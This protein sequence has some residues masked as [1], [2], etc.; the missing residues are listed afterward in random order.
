[1]DRRRLG[2]A[3]LGLFGLWALVLVE[4]CGGGLRSAHPAREMAT[5][6]SSSWDAPPAGAPPRASRSKVESEA[7]SSPSSSA[8]EEAAPEARLGLGTEWGERRTSRVHEVAFDRADEDRPFATVAV[9]YNDTAGLDA[10]ARRRR[11]RG[12]SGE[13]PRG[14]TVTVT[15]TDD[16]GDALPAFDVGGRSFVTG[17]V[18]QRYR[19]VLANH[20]DQR[21]ECVATVDGLDVVNGRPGSFAHRGYLLQPF[22]TM[23]IDGFRQS[24]DAV[25][26]FRFGAVADSYAAQVGS[27][28]NVG[29]IG[30]AFFHERGEEPPVAFRDR[31]QDAE[32]RRRENASPFPTEPARYARPPR[33]W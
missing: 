23:A 4:G 25:A 7:S 15:V 3:S 21:V 19:I 33:T 22:A 1:M 10:M 18:G 16:D 29:V 20:S 9:S 26:T 31:D 30:V 14:G 11:V 8:R 32:V 6:P 28:R 24:Q 2:I 17:K 13:L 27:A 5:S 12:I